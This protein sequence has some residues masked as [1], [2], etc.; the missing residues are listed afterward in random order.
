MQGSIYSS[1]LL[2]TL[3]AWISGM[4][5]GGGFG[6]IFASLLLLVW[7]SNPATRRA[8]TLVPW[9]TVVFSLLLGVWSPFF[10]PTRLGI[11]TLTGL[12]TAGLSVSLIAFPMLVCGLYEQWFPQTPRARAASGVRT[13]L[14]GAMLA[15]LA[16][17]LVGGGG[18][19]VY[20]SQQVNLLNPGEY[21]RWMV[22]LSATALVLDLILGFVEYGL[23][24]SSEPPVLRTFDRIYPHG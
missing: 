7:R 16:T 21:L 1:H 13:L 8:L 18:V 23:F 20:L 12:V 14:F 24:Q 2:I 4:I 10:L 6:S 19:G 9:R 17:G 5:V 15:A 22:I 11:G 3:G